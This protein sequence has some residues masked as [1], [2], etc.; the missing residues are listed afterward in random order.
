M[1]KSQTSR[2][3]FI[4]AVLAVAVFFIV[5]QPQKLF[6]SLPWSEKLNLKPGI[7]MVGGT[8]LLYEIKQPEGGY[9]SGN[10]QTLAEAVMES[11]KKRV[12]PNGVR[13][14]IWRPQGNDRLEIQMPSSP[15]TAQATTAREAYAKAQAQLEATN[16]RTPEVIATVETMKGQSRAAKLQQL[17]AGNPA[18]AKLFTD[19]AATYD[20]KAAAHAPARCRR[21]GQANVSVRRAPRY[22]RIDQSARRPTGSRAR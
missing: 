10:G 22:G 11:L 12:D 20:A 21:R 2:V 9:H 17:A 18:R 19:L 16:V 15:M 5:P 6:S 13:N 3:I 7:D 8:S 1:H 4:L 14:L